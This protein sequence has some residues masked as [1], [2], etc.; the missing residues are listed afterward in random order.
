MFLE[1]SKKI[2]YLL[3][4]KKVPYRELWAFFSV[5]PESNKN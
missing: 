2:F 4:L 5:S 3:Q 1:K